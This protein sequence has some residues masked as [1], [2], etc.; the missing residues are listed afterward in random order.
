MGGYD[1]MENAW[2]NPI[3]PEFCQVI[4]KQ[5]NSLEFVASIVSVWLAIQNKYV[6]KEICFLALGDNSSAVGWLH[7]ANMDETKN[8][9]LHIVSRKYAKVLMEADCC[10]YSQHINRF[11]NNVADALSRKYDSTDEDLTKFICL[12]FPS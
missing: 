8:L 1:Y 2:R 9:P 10:V 12:N 5:N 7:K 11:H 4:L 6:E 3:P